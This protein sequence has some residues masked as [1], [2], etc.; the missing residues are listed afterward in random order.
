MD[1]VSVAQAI[2]KV[3]ALLAKA[4]PE[5]LSLIVGVVTAVLKSDDPV[6]AAQR[7]AVAAASSTTSEKLIRKGLGSRG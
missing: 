4:P 6:R 1:P 2:G 5:V 3:A 7:A